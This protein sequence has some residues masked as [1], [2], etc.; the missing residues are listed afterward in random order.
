[1]RM[2]LACNAFSLPTSKEIT[3]RLVIGSAVFGVGWGLAGVCPGPAL[4]NLNAI[5][6]AFMA[7]GMLATTNVKL[8]GAA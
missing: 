5:F 3:S 2:P 7:V 8:G 1:M 4:A 6:V